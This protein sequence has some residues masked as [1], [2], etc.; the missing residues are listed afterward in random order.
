[1]ASKC[2]RTFVQSNQ[3]FTEVLLVSPVCTSPEGI[4]Y[5]I[6]TYDVDVV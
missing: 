2:K 5:G 1:M 4:T 6:S 3:R